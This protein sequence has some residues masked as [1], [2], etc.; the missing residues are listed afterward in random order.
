MA[1]QESFSARDWEFLVRLPYRVGVWMSHQDLG[2]GDKAAK[3][4]YQALLTVIQ[5]IQAKYAD[6]GLLKSLSAALGD[7]IAEAHAESEKNWTIVLADIPRALALFKH[8]GDVVE[9][10][11]FKLVLVDV[12]EAVAKAAPD[13]AFGAHNLFGGPEKGWFGLYPILAKVARLGRGPKVSIQEKQAIN[14][15]I[16]VLEAQELVRS[17]ELQPF[18]RDNQA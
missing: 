6:I 14:T 13:R 12:A 5:R 9:L 8:V 16:Q 11:C 10:N 15:L 3:E 17:W 1:T 4:E 2:G 7:Q 18:Q